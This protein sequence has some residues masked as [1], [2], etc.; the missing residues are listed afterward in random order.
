MERAYLEQRY[1]MH[2]ATPGG[3][4]RYAGDKQNSPQAGYS[5]RIL[6]IFGGLKSSQ[7]NHSASLP[8]LA[9]TDAPATGDNIRPPLDELRH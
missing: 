7:H 1:S 2:G 6:F 8:T 4:K 5:S 9:P 3:L